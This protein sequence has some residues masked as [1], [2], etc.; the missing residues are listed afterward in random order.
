MDLRPGMPG[1]EPHPL[2]RLDLGERGA[3]IDMRARIGTPRG[4]RLADEVLHDLIVL[5][6]EPDAQAGSRDRTQ[7]I[8]EHPVVR[9]GDVADRL[10]EEALVADDSRLG[11]R[12]DLV[13]VLLHDHSDD[14]EIAI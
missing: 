2:D 9:R 12:L 10:A 7:P 3:R 5:G 4:F 13:D 8:E 6:V 11:H 1:E 14:P